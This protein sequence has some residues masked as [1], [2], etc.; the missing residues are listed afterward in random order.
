MC[1][2]TVYALGVKGPNRVICEYTSTV[3][4][5]GDSVL[6]TDIT[7]NELRV[8]GSLESVDLIKNTIIIRT[9]E[10]AVNGGVRKFEMIREIFNS[11]DN[12]QMRDVDIREIET[13]DPEESVKEFLVGRQVSCEKL[14]KNDGS[15]IFDINTDGL[16]QRISFVEISP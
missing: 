15:V 3:Q 7:G 8:A 10:L 5:L 12:N 9:P 11:C 2:S 6:L 1:L 13:A 16:S 14:V 4:V